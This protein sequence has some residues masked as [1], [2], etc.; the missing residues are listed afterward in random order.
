MK[1]SVTITVGDLSKEIVKLV[2][3]SDTNYDAVELVEEL[4]HNYIDYG[5]LG[6]RKN[7]DEAKTVKSTWL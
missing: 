3:E 7:P 2:N 4:L 6:T 5:K 1:K